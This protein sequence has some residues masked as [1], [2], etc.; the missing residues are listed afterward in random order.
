MA[1]SS[2]IEKLA[3]SVWFI[4]VDSGRGERERWRGRKSGVG[5]LRRGRQ[6]ILTQKR[7]RFT[8]CCGLVAG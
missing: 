4:G 6:V 2:A 7:F 3:T 1:T 8:F 5:E